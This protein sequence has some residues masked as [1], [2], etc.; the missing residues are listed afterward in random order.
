MSDRT[1]K[2]LL[3]E[4]E[5][6]IAM[7]QKQQ[8]ERLGYSVDHVFTGEAA[9]T[10]ALDV[11]SRPDLI[12]MDIDL[13]TGI[14][15]TQAAERIRR[16]VDIPVIFLS[17]HTEPEIVAKTEKITSYGYVT[18]NSGITVL[19][20]SIK[21]AMRLFVAKQHIETSEQEYRRLFE[22][23]TTGV[24]YQNR[25]GIITAANPAAERM[26][27]LTIAEM[28]G[29]T[30]MN[31]RWKMIDEE[32]RRV[33]GDA[34]PSM[35]ALR[36]GATVGPVERGVYRPDRN[37]YVW[38]LITAT[39][40]FNPGEDEPYQSYATLED[41]TERKEI[42]RALIDQ[43]EFLETVLETTADGF[44]VVMM[45]GTI[46]M[47]NEAYRRMSGYS[48]E[49]LVGM[50]V[51]D[52]EVLEDMQETF[53]RIER[54]INNGWEIFET[55]HRRKDGTLLDVEISIS[56][57]DRGDEIFFVSFCRDISTRKRGDQEIQHQL[58]E[59]EALLKEVHHRIK[60]NLAQIEGLLVMQASDTDSVTAETALH[61]AASGVRS[62][63]VLYERLLIGTG[64]RDI[65]MRDYITSLID[66]L[67]EIFNA[68]SR[69]TIHQHLAD[70]H[71]R[72]RTAVPVGIILNE[73]LTNT[74]KYAFDDTGTGDVW[75][76]LEQRE[77][78]VTLT[79]RD[80]GIGFD[81]CST[82]NTSSGF[83]LTIVRMLAE[84]LEGTFTV[85]TDSGTT[86]V[87]A[88]DV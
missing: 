1:Q 26:L 43:E 53:E 34:H 5:A 67:N 33:P 51:N 42:E 27:G 71:L 88:F 83:G 8:L 11:A 4:D 36:T 35:V 14:D 25:D 39:P 80:N 75:V 19:D 31:P 12:L 13:G 48:R 46:S 84:Q 54:V 72:A 61:E 2:L 24:V 55:Q 64:Y 10:H 76:H 3:V 7:N 50:H 49:E 63:R 62:I 22:T 86:S 45:D 58:A 41:I 15:G 85:E 28:N 66:S 47:V 87:V 74:F 52:L 30:S 65:S 32:G 37:D 79:V 21:M 70:F 40:L 29:M 16:E 20:T 18:K 77:Q 56:R 44:W 23:M 69:I 81:E 82:C 60:N 9:V 78:R 6:L 38:L 73:L 17:S 57:V 68:H 59:K